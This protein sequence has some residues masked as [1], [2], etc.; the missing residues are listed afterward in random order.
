M[1]QMVK[2]KLRTLRSLH[3]KS[4]R[5]QRRKKNTRKGQSCPHGLLHNT[6]WEKIEATPHMLRPIVNQW[7]PFL[8]IP[9]K[10][11]QLSLLSF[12]TKDINAFVLGEEAKEAKRYGS[13]EVNS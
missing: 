12:H 1:D 13:V 10:T 4:Y 6:S 11:G 8:E 9:Q 5:V 3:S 7:R 2:M